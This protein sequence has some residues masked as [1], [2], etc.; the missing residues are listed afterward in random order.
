M[1]VEVVCIEWELRQMQQADPRHR[2]GRPQIRRLQ[3]G[4]PREA[5]SARHHLVI[6]VVSV[7]I[8]RC[9]GERSR[10]HH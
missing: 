7:G 8:H 2:A 4:L 9:P 3:A 5:C 10:P 1:G 6:V